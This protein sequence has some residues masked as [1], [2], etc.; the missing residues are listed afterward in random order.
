MKRWLSFFITAVGLILLTS[1]TVPHSRVPTPERWAS[2]EGGQLNS[3]RA[4][5]AFYFSIPVDEGMREEGVALKI[6]TSGEVRSGFLRIELRDP[7]GQT[8]WDSGRIGAGEFSIRTAYD[9]SSAPTGIYQLG[10]VYGENIAV[11]YNL[12][13]HTLYL[14]MGILFPGV[15]MLAVALVFVVFAARRQW[16]DWR[17]LGLGAFFWGFTVLLKFAFAIPS[18]AVVFR[19][20]GVS[21]EQVFS[22]ANLVAYLYIGALTGVFEAGLA[23]LVLRKSRWGQATREQAL[24]FGIGFG[25]FEAFLLGGAGL[26]TALVAILAPDALPVPTLGAL[27]QNGTLI[28]GLAPV[29]E[30]LAVILAHIFAAVLIFYAIARGDVKWAW[31]AVLYKTLLDA[32][33]GL[34]SFWGVATPAKLWT[35][36]AVVALIGLIGLWGTLQIVRRYPQPYAPV[37]LE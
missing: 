5:E 11:T 24:T 18:N 1:C 29:V 7:D 34:A 33:G 37:R 17:Y 10:I 27:A 32:P 4:G 15:G 21:Y 19:A 16:L 6:R 8:V 36:E 28:M 23:Y 13:W 25:A 22:P 30:R 3:T 31:F 35:I 2:V 26:V 14:G 9:L 12:A 20:L